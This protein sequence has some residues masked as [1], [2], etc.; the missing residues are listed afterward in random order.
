MV[1][2][3]AEE[4]ASAGVEAKGVRFA[5]FLTFSDARP[6]PLRLRR[7]FQHPLHPL[8]RP[9]TAQALNAYA[10]TAHHATSVG[11]AVRGHFTGPDTLNLLVAKG[12]RMEVYECAGA[13]DGIRLVHAANVF[14]RIAVM[15]LFRPQSRSTDL[16]FLSTERY[17]YCVLSWDVFTSSFHTEVTGDASE[18]TGRPTDAGQIGCVDPLARCVALHVYQGS[19]KI[20]AVANTEVQLRELGGRGASVGTS[21][22]GVGAGANST[23]TSTRTPKL[24]DLSLPHV[25]RLDENSILSLCFLHVTDARTRPTLA[26]LYQDHKDARHLRTYSVNMAHLERDLEQGW[27]LDKVEPGAAVLVA[28]PG[29]V[30]G[31]LIIGEQ[32]ISYVDNSGRRVVSVPMEVTIVKAATHLASTPTSSRFLLADHYGSLTLLL[33]HINGEGIVNSMSLEPLG[34]TSSPTCL[35][36]LNPDLVFVGSHFGDSQLLHLLTHPSTTAPPTDPP[37]LFDVLATYPSLSP[38]VDFTVVDLDGRGQG[39][40]VAC[41]GGFKD[42]SVRVVRNGVG[43]SEIAGVEVEGVRGVWS[44]REGFGAKYH[45]TLALSFAAETRFLLVDPSTSELSEHDPAALVSSSPSLLLATMAAD[46]VLQVTPEAVVLA[47]KDMAMKLAEWTPEG[48]AHITAAACS[49]TQVVVALAGGTVVYFTVPIGRPDLEFVSRRAM[50]QEVACVDVSPLREGEPA[51][52]VAVGLW[53]DNSVRVLSVPGLVEVEREDVGGD[54]VP[55]SVVMAEL[56]GVQYVMVGM[57]DGQLITYLID[58]TGRLSSRRKVSLGS[59]PIR[60]SPFR[61]TPSSPPHVFASS[62]RPTIVHSSGRKLLFSPVDLRDVSSAAPFATPSFP[63]AVAVATEDRLVI[64]SV[65]EV[66]KVHVKSIP[67]GEMPR[68]IAHQEG[69]KTFGIATSRVVRDPTGTGAEE[70][71]G[72][73]RIVDERSFEALDSL[74][75]DAT[76]LPTALTSLTFSGHTTPVYVLGT[77]F[78]DPTDEDEPSRGRILVL[79]VTEMKRVRVVAQAEVL[80][81]VYCLEEMKGRVVAGVNSKVLMYRLSTGDDPV[82]IR[83]CAHHGH[84]LALQLSVLG[85]VIAV[86]D[87]M[88]SVSY[89][90]Y[91]LSGNPPTDTLVEVARDYGTNWMTAVGM[92]D[93]NVAVGAESSYNML[94]VRRVEDGTEDDR[95]RLVGVGEWHLGD[96]VNR[97]RPGSLVMNF[98]D[99]DSPGKP[100]LLFVT[101]NGTVGVIAIL[102]PEVYTLLQ[103]VEANINCILKPV[104]GFEHAYWRS[105]CNDQRV[106]ESTGF[107]DGDI[108]ERFLDLSPDQKEQ[109]VEGKNGGLRLEVDVQTLMKLVEDLSRCCH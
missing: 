75:L 19:V 108:V 64:G 37:Q 96:M 9:T 104:G 53:T 17:Q 41:C 98:P 78:S 15:E 65:D 32:T 80:G 26:V 103:K 40:V 90:S 101:V 47:D 43:V 52:F 81:A 55:R 13:G 83:V 8:H 84:I 99:S 25:L 100:V 54:V 87:L 23:A 45:T 67:L 39:T 22:M 42:G 107:I 73:F 12:S 36:H 86:A 46:C 57:G 93:A 11:H 7:P 66:T 94:A 105:F 30:G 69:S 92:V 51:E 72:Y 28:V 70:E 60:L 76:E 38:I 49:P 102:K 50:E 68:R 3:H 79:E 14:G 10:V 1:S 91:Q 71:T 82:L 74:E 4:D 62:D 33:L 5:A 20:F 35:V 95:K 63:A 16:L 97:F 77:A 88:K 59:Q 21:G 44:L 56:E 109:V 29:P 18:R 85:E 48:G 61:P 58:P 2:R 106:A 6:R 31:V 34:V 24:G 89:L 27:K